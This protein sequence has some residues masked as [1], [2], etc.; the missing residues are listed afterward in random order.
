MDREA[1]P[2]VQTQNFLKILGVIDRTIL[3]RKVT[4]ANGPAS[5][6][7]IVSRRRAFSV[8]WRA[9]AA[10]SLVQS[11]A[12]AIAGVA[13]GDAPVAIRVEATSAP[14]TDRAGF[15]AIEIVNGQTDGPV[16]EGGIDFHSYR[17]DRTGWPVSTAPESSF[18]MLTAAARFASDM[19]GWQ[20]RHQDKVASPMLILAV[21]PTAAP[22]L[23]VS[24]GND[25]VV[26]RAGLAQ[27][28]QAVSKWQSGLKSRE[29]TGQ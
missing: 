7:L 22:D 25:V 2:D 15:T 6:P 26:A 9:A 13:R 3:P 8:E 4:I 23:S 14:P 21:S 17:F 27:L 5:L 10:E 16:A 12:S 11:L 1:L 24:I 19:S 18:A 28:G 20:W 29:K